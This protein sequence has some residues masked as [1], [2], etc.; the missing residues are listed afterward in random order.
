L[1]RESSARLGGSK[2]RVKF[3]PVTVS[4]MSVELVSTPETPVT[5]AVYV[6]ATAALLAFKVRELWLVVLDG[7]KDAVT[8]LG[9][10]D[11]ARLTK[12]LKPFWPATLMV[13]LPLPARKSV[14]L[15]AE[16]ERLKLGTT[17]VSVI[18]AVPLTLPEIPVRVSG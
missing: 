13:L 12:P 2:E 4:A 7:L 1:I 11:T 3:G 10:P 16:D 9:T 17:T 8:P 15:A 14:R 5:V 6:P 18:A